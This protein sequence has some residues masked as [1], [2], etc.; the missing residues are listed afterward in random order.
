MTEHATD[1]KLRARF[2]FGKNWSRF[3]GVL[4]SEHIEEAERS[5]REML[6]VH[7]LR[8][9]RFLDLGSGSGIFSLA[10]RRLGAY[11]HSFDNDP[12]SVTCTAELKRRYFPND[13]NWFIEEASVLDLDHV[14]SIGLFDV[15]YS[16]GVLHHTGDMWRALDNA[17]RPVA[18]GGRLYVAIYNDQGW[19]SRYWRWVKKV[20]NHDALS[21]LAIIAVHLP[22]LLGARFAVRAIRGKIRLE[23]GMSLWHDMLDWLGGY[24][25]ETAKP[26]EIVSFCG[27]HGLNLVT[28]R[29]VG[30]KLGCNEFIFQRHSEPNGRIGCS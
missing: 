24:P 17:G 1:A 7:D 10:A 12:E 14:N 27:C 22:Y 19:I 29:T 26:Q 25:F 30:R 15:V 4:N 16:W 11:V 20:Y 2:E 13:P 3:L 6:E 28:L 18:P 8:N 9:K 23:R 5:L 21:R